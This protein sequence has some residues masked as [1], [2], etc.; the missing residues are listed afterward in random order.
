ML[1]CKDLSYKLGKKW[2]IKEIS[3]SFSPGIVTGILGPNGSGKTTFFKTLAAIWEKSGG[4]VWWKGQDLLSLPRKQI[5][6]IISIVPQTNP[7]PFDYTAREIVAM[8]RYCHE[9]SP[10]NM[11]AVEKA[12][13][14]VDGLQFAERK[15]RELSQGERQRVFIARS[16]ATES[17]VLLL[18]E[19]TSNLD[20]RHQLQLW[21]LVRELAKSGKTVIAAHHD[22]M[23]VEQHFDKVAIFHKGGCV[24]YGTTSQVLTPP[25]LRE[26]FGV[27]ID[28]ENRLYTA[29]SP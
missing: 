6:K 11:K 15:I 17:N 2:L 7:I 16:L 25:L 1:E 10:L 8:G 29:T 28:Q 22:L 5:S 23:H 24:S 18:D 3:L 26:V 13:D 27:A 12:L 14:Q 4:T 20:I 9:G 21:E 19:P